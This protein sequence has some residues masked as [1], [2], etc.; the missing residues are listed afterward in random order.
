MR[1]AASLVLALV[2]ATPALAQTLCGD[3]SEFLKQLDRSYGEHT[4]ALGIAA[5]GAVLEVLTSEKG[6]WTI[7][8]TSPKGT[9]CVVATGESWETVHK[10]ARAPGA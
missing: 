2:S 6:S 9:T 1:L 10:I 5:N 3:R 7:L 8:V 4:E